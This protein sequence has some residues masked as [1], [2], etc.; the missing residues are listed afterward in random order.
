MAGAALWR[1]SKNLATLPS[2]KDRTKW[3]AKTKAN[4]FSESSNESMNTSSMT[5]VY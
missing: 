5:K 3:K 1:D 4:T 2:K